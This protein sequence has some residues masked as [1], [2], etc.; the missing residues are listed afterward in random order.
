MNRI[1][2]VLLLAGAVIAQPAMAKKKSKVKVDSLLTAKD[3]PGKSSVADF[4]KAVKDAK[5]V[6][7]M[8][9]TY[10]TKDGKLY[11]S[12]ADSA[13]T[14][15]YILSNRVSSTSNT[16]D[17]VAGQMVDGPRLIRFS[18]DSVRVYLHLVQNTNV[19][20]KGDPITASFKTNF[21]DPIL[22]AF[23]IV[24]KKDHKVLID[25]TSFFGGNEKSLSP[26]KPD[27]P[28]SVLFGGS[29]NLKGS[30]ISDASGV[31]EVKAFPR[32]IEIISSLSFDLSKE[33][34]PY[35][36]VMHRSLFMAPENPMPMRLQD[37]RVGFFSTD[38]KI[39]SSSADRV[40]K[41][42]YI[43]RW[44][45]EPKDEDRERYFRGELVEPKKPIVFYVDSA[46]PDKWR[47]TVKQGIE[48]WNKAFEA[49]GF[50]NA[51]KAKDYPK[52]DSTFDPA[53]MRYNCIKYAVTETANAMGPSYVDPRTGEILTADVIWYH[54]VI[55]LLHNWRFVQT[56][57]VD[58]R[59]HKAVFDDDLMKESVRYVA[60]HEVGHTLGLM[61]NMGASYSFPVDSLRSPSFTQKYGTTPSIMDYAR[62]N[63][64]A[65][66][67]DL[68]RGVKLTPPILGVE[69]IYAINWGYRLIKD[70]D[71]PE[72]EKPT[73]DA[74]IKAK[75]GDPMYEFGAQQF[76]GTIDPTDQSEDLG[77]DHIKA[78]NYAISNL[79]II[80]R[81]LEKWVYKPGD[82]YEAV[83]DMYKQVVSQYTRHLFHVMPYIGG[84][85]FEEIR[86][87]DNKGAARH[88]M[89]RATQKR[90]MQ[91][92][93]GQVRSY[94]SWLSPQSLLNKLDLPSNVNERL[95]TSVV[96]ALYAGTR[97]FSISEGY[98]IDPVKNYSLDQYINDV[99]NTLFAPTMQGRALSE[100]DLRLQSG[101]INLF[102]LT[103]GLQ[104]KPEKKGLSL[105]T[106]EEAD[107]LMV[108]TTELACCKAH[109]GQSFMRI[110]Y[111]LPS[112][113]TDVMAPL[114]LNQLKKVRSLYGQKRATGDSKTRNF[115]EYQ[116]LMIDKLLKK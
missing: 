101:V 44:R 15:N 114:M 66:P 84:V 37:N 71:T 29:R 41:K 11:F 64:I 92:L 25:M 86:Q 42:T 97:L 22:K 6:K 18:T 5:L 96:G 83:E 54:N 28:L 27:N 49:A 24:G 53:D 8:F 39:Y 31:T 52:N 95:Q 34:M 93:I 81:N 20:K 58:A 38:K 72:K 70:A 68:E 87:G 79:K 104:P 116:I 59:T 16:N 106:G 111:G 102:K 23:K 46:F 69:D 98:K 60:A 26:M 100:A 1:L 7:G 17:Y 88:Y 13:F 12:I 35:T 2:F 90:A 110:I 3:K 94:D 47:S 36:V 45:L 21:A 10:L 57:A 77:N 76:M 33:N 107:K 65:Q 113:S 103:S 115:Y 4:N 73:L 91:W 80:M 14:R 50:K 40:E 51:I 75:S 19:V 112:L 99:F 108:E 78:G 61:H 30:F 55:S 82:T 9:D 32:N 56:G 63:F 105:L 62:N 48:D 67:G 74:W 89:D 85:R 43:H 109:Q